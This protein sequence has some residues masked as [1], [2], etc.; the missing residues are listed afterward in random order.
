MNLDQVLEQMKASESQVKTAAAPA[1]APVKSDALLDALQ[2]T[3]APARPAGKGNVVDDLM[4]MASELA[5]T[6]RELEIAHAAACG[7]A[8]ADTAIAKFAAYDAQVA[9]MPKQA[10]VSND[11]DEVVK[12]A[13]ETGYADAVAEIQAAS[14]QKQA[15]DEDEIVKQ[16]AEVGYA[17]AVAEIQAA[18]MQKQASDD[19]LVKQAAA[20]GYQDT[21]VKLAEEYKAGQEQ[22]LVDVHNVAVG[23]FLKGAAEAEIMIN[24]AKQAAAR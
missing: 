19:E 22:A 9:S 6:E 17:D 14:M 16:A 15:S 23:E 21:Q 4:K 11:N 20:A 1:P 5:G 12:L 24:Q 7:G 10:A 3:A 8:F 2:K 18:G 13:A